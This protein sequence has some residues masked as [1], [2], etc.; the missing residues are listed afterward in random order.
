M[1]VF[2]CGGCDN[3]LTAPVSQVALP[4]LVHAYQGCERGWIAPLLEPGT[5][6]VDPEPAGPPW[7]AWEEIDT[8]EA[9]ARGIYAP[10]SYLPDGPSGA[11]C[12]APGDIRG[13]VLIPER[14]DASCWGL[15][16]ADGPNLVCTQCGHAVATRVDHC[17]HWQVI[18]LDPRA[19]HRTGGDDDVIGWEE[20]RQAVEPVPPVEPSGRWSPLWE[21]A[22][23]AA[24]AHLLAVSEGH[25]VIM[26]DGPIA[27]VFRQ[28]LDVLLPSGPSSWTLGLDGPGLSTDAD[29]ALV[30]QHPQT[31]ET[32]PR[33]TG[34]AVPLPAEVWTHLA[35]HDDRRLLLA[36]G[37][38]PYGVRRDD[39]PPPLPDQFRPDERV[40]IHTLARLPAV[41]QPWL[42]AIHER[43]ARTH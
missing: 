18:W 25:R 16:G 1:T 22:A 31:A 11:I 13:T 33:G 32:W 2:T 17:G 21:A 34:A 29:I 12:I 37:S 6:A 8:A 23:G 3:A 9:E 27:Q 5:F 19:V 4:P 43:F 40:F 10:T 20:L 36:I 28:T 24:L 39:P 42:R 41:R 15:Y 35:A 38:L 14:C 30:P 26:P 7:R